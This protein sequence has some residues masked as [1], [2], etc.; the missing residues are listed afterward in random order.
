MCLEKLAALTT[1]A[2]LVWPVGYRQPK[3]DVGYSVRNPNP[4]SRNPSPETRNPD[5]SF[6]VFLSAGGG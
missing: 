6:I 1:T 4:E 2:H 5:S 3:Q